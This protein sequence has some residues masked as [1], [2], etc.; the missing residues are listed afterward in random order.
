M[1][2]EKILEAFRNGAK[3]SREDWKG[4]C[5]LVIE[6]GGEVN[7]H[8]IFQKSDKRYST[9]EECEDLSIE[10]IIADDWLILSPNYK[11]N[12]V[13]TMTIGGCI[14]PFICEKILKE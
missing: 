9:F 8:Y 13:P 7:Q 12:G 3:I 10:S 4:D 6:N 1:K 14:E 5:Y 2:F 11:L